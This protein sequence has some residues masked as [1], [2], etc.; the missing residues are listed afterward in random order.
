MIH[1]LKKCKSGETTLAR[2][3]SVEIAGCYAGALNL[4]DALIMAL[5]LAFAGDRLQGLPWTDQDCVAV[6][7]MEMP[8]LCGACRSIRYGPLAT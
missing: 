8:E 1:P 5:K 2:G 7:L 4:D 6:R 3:Y